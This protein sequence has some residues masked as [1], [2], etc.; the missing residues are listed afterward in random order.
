M[1]R[2]YAI[3]VIELTSPYSAL[4]A[5]K[6]K[7]AVNRSNDLSDWRLTSSAEAVPTFQE[8]SSPESATQASMMDTLEAIFRGQA[9]YVLERRGPGLA[10][11][12]QNYIGSA[13]RRRLRRISSM[14][15]FA[16]TRAGR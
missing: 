7:Q 4:S 14:T 11:I 8:R 9:N 6:N 1:E 13:V 2:I 3:L 16:E 15:P 5:E 12:L 10:A